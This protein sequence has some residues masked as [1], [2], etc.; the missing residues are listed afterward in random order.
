MTRDTAKKLVPIIEAYAQGKTIQV[1]QEQSNIW[2]DKTSP[3]FDG[4]PE[5]YRI[6]PEPIYV[7]YSNLREVLEDSIEHNSW[8]KN[9]NTGEIVQILHIT[10]RR[11]MIDN[12]NPIF[13]RLFEEY[14]WWDGTPCGKLVIN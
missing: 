14:T 2:A 9:K 6:K 11:V 3:C 7:P 10:H 1:F 4:L 5:H 12:D 8:I 13:G